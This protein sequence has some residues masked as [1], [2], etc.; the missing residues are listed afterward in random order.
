MKP[1]IYYKTLEEWKQAG[2]PTNCIV[3]CDCLEGLKELPD[4]YVDLVVTDPPYGIDADKSFKINWKRKKKYLNF[5]KKCCVEFYRILKNNGSMYLMC[6]RVNSH[7]IKLLLDEIFEENN[8]RSEIVWNTGENISGFKSKA[9]NWIYS[10]IRIFY[11]VKTNEFIFNKQY[12]PC[13]SNP[14][15][16]KPCSDIWNDILSFQYSSQAKKEGLSFPTQKPIELIK[17][18]L[19]ASSNKGN[20]VLDSFLGSGTTAVT[21]KRLGRNFIGFEINPEYCKIAVKRLEQENI[22]NWLK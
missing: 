3:C 18:I 13:K 22:Q 2:K 20:L 11:Y 5:I 15:K 19:K 12:I 1:K 8:F 9:K 4:N 16:L 10:Q 7:K 6:D 21:C 14:N 17:R